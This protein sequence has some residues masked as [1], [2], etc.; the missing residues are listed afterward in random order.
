MMVGAWMWV[1]AVL[2]EPFYFPRWYTYFVFQLK[3][4]TLWIC[5]KLNGAGGVI[6]SC[7]LVFL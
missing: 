7:L 1:C 3:C 5:D 2:F 4:Y 6:T